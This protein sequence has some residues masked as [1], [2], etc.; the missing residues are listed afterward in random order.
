MAVKGEGG[1]SI[2]HGPDREGVFAR[3][4]SRRLVM[5]RSLAVARL[6]ERTHGTLGFDRRSRR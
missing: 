1:Y 4:T 6:G 5:G 2:D 3:I